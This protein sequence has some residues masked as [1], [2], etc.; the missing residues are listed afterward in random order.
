MAQGCGK[1][2]IATKRREETQK[3]KNCRARE[4]ETVR[5]VSS[6]EAGVAAVGLDQDVL[7]KGTEVKEAGSTSPNPL[8]KAEGDLLCE[9]AHS[10][11]P[12][13]WLALMAE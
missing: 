4:C 13:G 6:C 7:Q 5:T 9:R 11:Q 3:L 8:P 12:R 2:R 1:D 10:V